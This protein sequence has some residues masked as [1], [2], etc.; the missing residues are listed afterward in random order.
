MKK[1]KMYFEEIDGEFCYTEE[2][3]KER[4]NSDLKEIDVFEAY[5]LPVKYRDKGIFWCK[6]EGF[7]GD[8]SQDTCGKQCNNYEPRNGVSGCCKAY[9]TALYYAGDKVTLKLE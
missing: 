9:T 6:T 3:I 4:T 2:R 1:E 7:C 5:K 8:D